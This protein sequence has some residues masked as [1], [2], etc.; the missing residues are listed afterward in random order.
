MDG[1]APIATLVL[2][3][4]VLASAIRAIRRDPRFDRREII[5]QAACVAAYLAWCAALALLLVPL[6]RRVGAAAAAAIG[7]GSIAISMIVLARYLQRRLARR[8]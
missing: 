5:V 4:A 3:A 8:R 6:G 2:V 1:A 7:I